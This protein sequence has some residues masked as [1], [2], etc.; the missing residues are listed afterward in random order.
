MPR[1]VEHVTN[2]GA[3]ARPCGWPKCR[4]TVAN[5]RKLRLDPK[6]TKKGRPPIYCSETCRTAAQSR[7]RTLRTGLTKIESE[8]L[9]GASNQARLTAWA[10][11]LRWEL[12]YLEFAMGKTPSRAT[13]T[14]Q[15]AA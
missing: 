6:S 1:T 5:Q 8:L 14:T 4:K 15:G 13:D 2:L 11:R 3:V 10:K 7:R 9:N 12:D